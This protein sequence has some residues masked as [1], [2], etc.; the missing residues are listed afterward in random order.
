LLWVKLYSLSRG[1]CSKFFGQSLAALHSIP[2]FLHLIPGFCS[3]S[4]LRHVTLALQLEC[5][6]A[7]S[8]TYN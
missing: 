1:A 8:A 5:S 3:L 6:L 4:Q 2:N 7:H